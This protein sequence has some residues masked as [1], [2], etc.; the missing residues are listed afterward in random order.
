MMRW[1]LVR[2]FILY[3]FN[4]GSLF[5]ALILTIK[6]NYDHEAEQLLKVQNMTLE[7]GFDLGSHDDIDNYLHSRVSHCWESGVGEE[8]VFLSFFDLCFLLLQILFQDFLRGLAVRRLNRYCFW[9]LEHG[10]PGYAEF[11]LA[12]NTL[13]LIYNQ[14][15]CWMATFFC[16]GMPLIFV[17]KLIILMYLRKWT[18]LTCN[19]PN[20]RIFRVKNNNFNLYLLL[21]MLVLCVI[22]VAIGLYSVAPSKDCGPFR[23]NIRMGFVIRF[24]FIIFA[25]FV[26]DLPKLVKNHMLPLFS[27]SSPIARKSTPKSPISSIQSL[28]QL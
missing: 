16:P 19:T 21:I 26:F 9:N 13:H 28:H 23:N 7:H 4:L 24:G 25:I 27:P 11:K 17:V 22:P 3:L 18:V 8:F 20:Q 5:N 6:K 10:F 1:Q 2:V 14:G 15:I 12:D